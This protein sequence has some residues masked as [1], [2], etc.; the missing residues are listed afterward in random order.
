VKR[1][2]YTRV[3]P[4]G[5]EQ[6]LLFNG[7]TG[8]LARLSGPEAR[9]LLSGRME[10]APPP[11]LERL[12]GGGFVVPPE[13]DELT[14]YRHAWYCYYHDPETLHLAIIPTQAC[15]M[16][17]F[18]CLARRDESRMTRETADR[19][20]DLAAARSRRSRRLGVTWFGGEPLLALETIEYLSQRLMEVAAGNGCRYEAVLFT[21]GYTL[22]PKT[23]D[24]LRAL[25]VVNITIP[26]DGP[27]AVHEGRRPHAGGRPTFDRILAN[28]AAAAQRCDVT[29]QSLVDKRNFD[30]AW[31][32]YDLL[33]AGGYLERLHFRIGRVECHLDVQDRRPGDLLGPVEFDRRY[34]QAL[35]RRRG[36]PGL[37]PY[38]PAL[39]LGC[40]YLQ[41]HSLAV[42]PAGRLYKCLKAVGRPQWAVGSVDSPP[43]MSTPAMQPWLEL[44]PCRRDD[45]RRCD[46]LPLCS[47]GCPQDY[48]E[49]GRAACSALRWTVDDWLRLVAE[50]PE[51][52]T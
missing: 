14:V 18:Y 22:T 48:L 8:A 10:D 28:A 46:V 20:V 7:L 4:T 36:R 15:D 38:R 45:C 26:L 2:R 51:V 1:S 6:C 49:H 37:E 33:D 52:A 5:D 27:R 17:C 43:R 23:V 41:Y 3:V 12:A 21:N 29:V 34:V 32:L 40:T 11:F 25:G 42:D 35:R 9:L 47:G 13:V 16:D 31:E 19:L 39:M 24:R 50:W 30:A 44:D